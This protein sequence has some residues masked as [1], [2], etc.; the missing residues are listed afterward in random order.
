MCIYMTVSRKGDVDAK[1]WIQKI[2]RKSVVRIG[3]VSFWNPL[4]C[5]RKFH[6]LFAPVGSLITGRIE[7]QNFK[8]R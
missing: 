4:K 8:I 5:V 3:Q 6:D 2:Q 1:F 7:L